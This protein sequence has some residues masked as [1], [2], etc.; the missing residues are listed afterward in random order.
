LQKG[1][2]ATQ[3]LWRGAQGT[4]VRTGGLGKLRDRRRTVRRGGVARERREILGI[5]G[6]VSSC[7]GEKGLSPVPFIGRGEEEKNRGGEKTA[8]APSKRH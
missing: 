1:R 5:F 4:T 3:K 8:V 2:G 6:E 7:R